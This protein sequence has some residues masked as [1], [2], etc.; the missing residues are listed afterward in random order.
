[1]ST[2][3]TSAFSVNKSNLFSLSTTYALTQT[4]YI[5][6]PTPTMISNPTKEEAT[7][8]ESLL[9]LTAILF[10]ILLISYYLQLRKIRFIHET[11]VSI[12][13]GAIVGAIISFS[14][15]NS[16]KRVL[17]FDHKSFFNLILP[18]IIL[19]SGYDLQ[20]VRFFIHIPIN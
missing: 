17:K 3:T 20:T 16:I 10:M 1:M 19:N 9:I 5:P 18:P 6:S 12:F 2:R 13:L 4:T 14:P 7:Y 15:G 8:A 11:V